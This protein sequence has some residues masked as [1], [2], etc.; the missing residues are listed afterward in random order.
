MGG[1][2]APTGERIALRPFLAGRRTPGRCPGVVFTE[3]GTAALAVAVGIACRL[4]SI[5]GQPTVLIPAYGCP[6]L[7]SAAA[8]NGCQ[9]KLVDLRPDSFRMSVANARD[10]ADPQTVALIGAHLLGLREDVEALHA[11]CRE[12]GIT[13]IEDAAQS[14]PALLVGDPGWMVVHSFGRGKPVSLLGGGALCLPPALHHR[15]PALEEPGFSSGVTALGKAAAYDLLRWPPAFGLAARLVEVGATRFQPLA[16]I[17]RMDDVRRRALARN[18][19]IQGQSLGTNTRAFCSYFD[20]CRH[21]RGRLRPLLG[22]RDRTPRFP[23]LCATPALR[24]RLIDTLEQAGLGASSMYQVPLTRVSGV[25]AEALHPDSRK[26]HP[27]AED[28]AAR[29]LTLPVHSRVK[30]RH[31]SQI[32]AIAERIVADHDHCPSSGE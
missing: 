26:R 27:R 15:L 23:L 10:Q 31:V 3:S 29:L 22:E 12:L 20:L 4:R 18:V 17:R 19:Q 1:R 28:F 30:A 32:V 5:D 11:L 14:P 8:F 7:I 25:P 2:L 6:D 24:N 9:V 16:R 21:S 13:F